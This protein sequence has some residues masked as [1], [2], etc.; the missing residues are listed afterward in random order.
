VANGRISKSRAKYILKYAKE[1]NVA[2]AQALRNPYAMRAILDMMGKWTDEMDECFNRMLSGTFDEGDFNI[3]FQT[4]KPF[5]FTNVIKDCGVKSKN[6]PWYGQ[7]M[8]SPHQNKNSEFL[9]LAFFDLV[10]AAT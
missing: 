9:V 1:I 2:D 7:L 4:I 3:I 6:S 10:S 5:M 8:R